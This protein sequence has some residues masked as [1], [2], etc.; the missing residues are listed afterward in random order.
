MEDIFVQGNGLGMSGFARQLQHGDA[1][2]MARVVIHACDLHPRTEKR[3]GKLVHGVLVQVKMHRAAIGKGD[4]KVL[5]LC[6]P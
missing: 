4:I 3:H 2:E 5:I 1:G 6:H